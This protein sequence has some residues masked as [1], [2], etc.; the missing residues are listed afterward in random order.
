MVRL[1]LTMLFSIAVARWSYSE[2][3]LVFPS[4]LPFID[5]ALRKV[6][7]PTHDKWEELAKDAQT[8]RGKHGI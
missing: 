4:A 8:L 3:K 2:V 5:F 6:E 7:I 1:L